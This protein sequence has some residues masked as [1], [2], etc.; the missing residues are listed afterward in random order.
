[1]VDLFL[2]LVESDE[3]LREHLKSDGWQPIKEL[4]QGSEGM[5]VLIAGTPKEIR[6]WLHSLLVS[7]R[8]K[9]AAMRRPKSSAAGRP[10]KTKEKQ[11]AQIVDLRKSGIP[12]RD[13][14]VLMDKPERT[15]KRWYHNRGKLNTK[16]TDWRF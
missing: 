6:T 1:M 11:V 16:N 2:R 9:R 5:R 13:I 15:V 3:E 4:P 7:R 12:W 10:R 8:M 14:A